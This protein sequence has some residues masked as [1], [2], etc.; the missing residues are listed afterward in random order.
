M[1]D[2][3]APNVT[4]AMRLLAKDAEITRLRAELAEAE[5]RGYRRGVEDARATIRTLDNGRSDGDYLVY[6]LAI[7]RCLSAVRDL[8]PA[9]YI[10]R[11]NRPDSPAAIR[12]P[13]PRRPGFP[14]RSRGLGPTQQH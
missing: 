12:A 14:L 3:R 9:T 8:D 2:D 11:T 10:S 4:D 1:S 13:N 6:N 5:A 7:M